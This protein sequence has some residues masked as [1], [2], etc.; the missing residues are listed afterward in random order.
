MNNT[1]EEDLGF[2]EVDKIV[3]LS[4]IG[5]KVT[6]VEMSAAYTKDLV[7]DVEKDLCKLEK[8]ME[9]MADS[10][11][12]VRLMM[13]DLKELFSKPGCAIVFENGRIEHPERL[14]ELDF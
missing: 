13:I 8:Q 11:A 14:I 1:Q 7:K 5:Q 6:E 10:M 2:N 3:A 12:K 4:L 9:Y